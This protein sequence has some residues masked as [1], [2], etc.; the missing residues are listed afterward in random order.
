[1][2]QWIDKVTKD[3]EEAF[4][5]FGRYTFDD[6]GPIEVMDIENFA[7]EIMSLSGKEAGIW[8]EA[9]AKISNDLQVVASSIYMQCDEMDE[10]WWDACSEECPSV[11]Y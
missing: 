9:L 11:D 1:M 4:Y 10:K 8:L 6:K 3:L 5:Y 2:K 7:E